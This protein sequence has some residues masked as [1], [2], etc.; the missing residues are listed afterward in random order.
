[1]KKN[2]LLMML[3][4]PAMLAA[5]NGVTVSGLA[6]DAGTVTFNVS[7]QSAGMPTL[8]SDT[9]WVFVDYNKNG[10]ME[11]LPLSTGATLTTTS[12]PGVGNVVPVDGNNQGV[13][14]VGNAR[15]AGSFSA[16]VQLLTATAN[17][18]GACV[19]ASNYPPVGNYTSATEISFTGTPPYEVVLNGDGGTTTQMVDGSPYRIPDTYAVQSCTDKNGAP[20]KQSC[21]PSTPYNLTASATTYCP[22]SSVTFALSNTTPGRTYRLYKDDNSVDELTGTGSAATFTSAFAGAGVY[23]AQVVAEGGNCAALMTGTHTVSENPLPTN[24]SLTASPTAICNG[25]SATLTAVAN[26]AASYSIDNSNWQT[27]AAFN[28][29]PSAS[30]YYT[31][32]AKTSAGCS[33]TKANA[34]TVTVNPLPA[35]TVTR[36]STATVCQGTNVVFTATGTA[37]STFTWT[38]SPAGI[39]SGTGN[40]SYT[41]SGAAVG[42]KS[43]SAYARRTSN[44]TT[45][46]SGNATSSAAVSPQGANGQSSAPCGCTTGTADCSGICTTTGTYTSNDGDCTG[47]CETAYVRTLDQC[48]AVINARTSTYQTIYCTTGCPT[49]SST[50]RVYD[51]PGDGTL[52]AYCQKDCYQWAYGWAY[53]SYNYPTYGPCT[54]YRCR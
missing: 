23:T 46:Q 54:C 24:L 3:C 39:A 20:G 9:V 40:W 16:T 13:W 2:L 25:Q 29:K 21:I 11:R 48:G 17:V 33:A 12:A 32:Y 4:C 15:T 1:M 38:G 41:V 26:G 31:L 42:T 49:Y 30:T 22:G 18:A 36:V 7:W 10:V 19:Y 34:A 14:V 47:T 35:V 8:W 45:C 50:C 53:W 51:K 27:T 44:G 43:V 52:L 28:V 5:Q 6:I 37:G